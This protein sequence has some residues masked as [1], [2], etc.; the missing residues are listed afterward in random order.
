MRISFE[1]SPDLMPALNRR[2]LSLIDKKYAGGLSADEQY[3]LDFFQS[4]LT[5]YVRPQRLRDEHE[6]FG[7]DRDGLFLRC[8]RKFVKSKE[9]SN[10]SA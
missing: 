9:N 10:D 3:E 7:H 2:R 1:I 5:A 8:W 4:V 6:G